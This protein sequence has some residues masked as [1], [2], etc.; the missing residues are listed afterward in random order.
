[1]GPHMQPSIDKLLDV[2]AAAM[3]ATWQIRELLQ[4]ACIRRDKVSVKRLLQ[5]PNAPGKA[6]AEVQLMIG[7]LVGDRT[8]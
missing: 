3:L 2:P 7:V 4:V 8:E 1:M 6:D 5:H